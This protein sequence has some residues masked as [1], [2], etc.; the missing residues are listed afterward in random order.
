MNGEHITGQSLRGVFS[1]TSIKNQ[2]Y[3]VAVITDLV[4]SYGG[5]H[6]TVERILV[7][8]GEGGEVAVYDHSFKRVATV[9]GG[10]R[11]LAKKLK[12]PNGIN[13]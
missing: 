3:P 10:S 12:G 8:D 6:S 5:L 13:Y 11:S 7:C 4:G 1:N 2:R 9:G